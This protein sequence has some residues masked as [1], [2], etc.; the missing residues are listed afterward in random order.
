MV[1]VLQ[2][3]VLRQPRD[4]A[5]ALHFYED[6]LGLVRYREW[7]EEPARGVVLFLGGGY[8][9][10]HESGGAAPPAGVRLWL[11]VADLKA[12]VTEL[13]DAGVGI[14]EA[15]AHKPWG[16]LEATVHDPDG[17]PLILIEVPRSHPLRRRES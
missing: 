14:D 10:L 6:Q 15:P 2:S 5:A 3:R 13:R 11:Q 17:M 12:A 4:F 7:G 1:H 8:L 9:E 16:L